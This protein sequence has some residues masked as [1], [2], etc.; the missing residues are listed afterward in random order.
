M[1]PS[2]YVKLCP[3]LSACGEAL[4]DQQMWCWGCDVRHA[5]E[6]L[7]LA[8]GCLK[9]PAPE[10]HLRSAYTYCLD[11]TCALTLW[12]W[13]IWIARES[14]GSLFISRSR[15][16]VRATMKVQL[17]PQAW[18]EEDLPLNPERVSWDHCMPLLTDALTWIATYEQ[19]VM[20]RAASGYRDMMLKFWPMRRRYRG[21]CPATEMPTQWMSLAQ[22]F[23]QAPQPS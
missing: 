6:N 5:D 12:G 15:F 8:Y 21:G 3:R 1:P 9:R 22:S 11:E 14:L 20:A 4:L 23:H 13:G 17:L 7:L 2:A 10:A 18:C 19:W 16:K